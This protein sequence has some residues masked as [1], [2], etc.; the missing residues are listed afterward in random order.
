M[1]RFNKLSVT[2]QLDLVEAVLDFAEISGPRLDL[3]AARTSLRPA[4]RAAAPR[5]RPPRSGVHRDRLS[6]SLWHRVSACD[7]LGTFQA[8]AQLTPRLCFAY[9]HSRQDVLPDVSQRLDE[10]G[11]DQERWGDRRRDRRG[12]LG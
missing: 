3:T 10:E 2:P 7:R 4:R 6:L 12:K 8:S 5:T 11:L 1:R 9:E